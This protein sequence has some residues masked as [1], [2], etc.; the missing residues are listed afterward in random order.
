M[1]ALKADETLET[2]IKL[3]QAKC[4]NNIIEQEHRRVKCIVK[5]VVGFQSFHIARHALQGRA[6]ISVTCQGQV[7]G[8]AQKDPVFQVMF[9]EKIFGVAA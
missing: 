7:Q 9:I 4:L 8:V 5:L 2:E 6:A 3:R 1:V